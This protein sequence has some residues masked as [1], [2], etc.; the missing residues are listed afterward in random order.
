MNNLAAREA[1]GE[2]LL[3]LNNDIEV[4]APNW[5]EAMLEHAQRPEVGAVGAKLV[6]PDG[7][8]QHAG[9]VVGIG[10]FA[11]HAFRHLDGGAPGYL[12]LASLVRDV[13]AVTGACMMVRRQVFES[14]GGF[15]ERLR[16]AFN[17]VDFCLR[18]GERGLGVVY[19]PHAVLT[20]H[21]SASRGALHPR[22]EYLFMRRRWGELVARGD[23]FYNPNLT[24]DR[25]DF[26]IDV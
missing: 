18:L 19:T 20:H 25:E 21:E 10:G 11:D 12:H 16:V 1:K 8:V 6:Y 5:I 24:L 13:S 26:G 17:D 7:T 14:L 9:V 15:D 22:S 4:V 3:F 2:V 23:P